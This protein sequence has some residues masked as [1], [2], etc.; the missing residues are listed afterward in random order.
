MTAATTTGRAVL[1]ETY[2]RTDITFVRGDGAWLEDGEGRRYLDLVG[3]IA[4][5]GSRWR[6]PSTAARS[7]PSR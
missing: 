7:A 4:V 3:G 1:L 6:I 2:A 5:V